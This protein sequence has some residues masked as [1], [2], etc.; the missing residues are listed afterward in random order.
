[1]LYWLLMMIIMV[2][3]SNNDKLQIVSSNSIR[4][5]IHTMIWLT[6]SEF[7]QVIL[8]ILQR[9]LEVALEVATSQRS[10]IGQHQQTSQQHQSN[11]Q[12]SALSLAGSLASKLSQQAAR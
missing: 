9:R 11:Q 10:I 2:I 3:I 6:V 5:L 7:Y 12:H 1:M 4:L 8:P